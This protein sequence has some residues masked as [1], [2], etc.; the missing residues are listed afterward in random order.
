MQKMNIDLN[1]R[2]KRRRAIIWYI[3]TLI[4][5]FLGSALPLLM[6]NQP[7]FTLHSLSGLN[8]FLANEYVH[9]TITIVLTSYFILLFTLHE[10]F[11]I[12]ASLLR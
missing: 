4:L 2:G 12:L 7:Y 3:A 8:Y 6:V 9:L 1:H 10:R 11:E 5:A